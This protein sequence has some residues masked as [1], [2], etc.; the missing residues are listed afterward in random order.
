[1]APSANARY[2]VAAYGNL[3]LKHTRFSCFQSVNNA[4]SFIALAEAQTIQRTLALS[5]M[6]H[7]PQHSQ[8]AQR[9]GILATDTQK[10]RPVDQRPTMH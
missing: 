7:P 10:H 9:F 4:A 5:A 6:A 2:V 8:A 1:M 3:E